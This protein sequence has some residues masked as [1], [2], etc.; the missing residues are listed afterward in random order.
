M[1]K[2]LEKTEKDFSIL[3]VIVPKV[4]GKLFQINK[5]MLKNNEVYCKIIK[6]D[7]ITNF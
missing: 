6:L 4:K 2:K 1:I 3:E 5:A 7:R